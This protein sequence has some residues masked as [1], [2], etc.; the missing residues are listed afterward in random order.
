MEPK[1]KVLESDKIYLRPFEP[2]DAPILYQAMNSDKK[3]RRLTGTHKVFTLQEIEDF[4]RSSAADSTRVGFAIVT[5]DD[6]TL[7]GDAALNEMVFPNNRDANFRIAIFDAFTSKGYGSEAAELML[8]YGFGILNLHRIELDV[9]SVNERAAHVYEKLGFKKE[10]VK[11]EN[12]YYDH[13]YYDSV[14]MSILEHEYRERKK[15]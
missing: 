5:Q 9:Y 13:Q 14:M 2:G 7:V 12:W 1:V 4:I 11:R 10:G 15:K 6:D 8:E 3:L